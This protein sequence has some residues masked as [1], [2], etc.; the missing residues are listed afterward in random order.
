MC[1]TLIGNQVQHI[2]YVRKVLGLNLPDH[3]FGT[4]GRQFDNEF[5]I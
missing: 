2:F 5:M 3:H 4:V 1:C